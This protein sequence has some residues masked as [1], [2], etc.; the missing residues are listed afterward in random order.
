MFFRCGSRTGHFMKI[1]HR[2]ILTAHAAQP[3]IAFAHFA[4]LHTAVYLSTFHFTKQF[5]TKQF[6][7][8]QCGLFFQSTCSPI[9]VVTF[10]MSFNGCKL[11]HL[12]LILIGWCAWSPKVE[13]SASC[14]SRDTPSNDPR[15]QLCYLLLKNRKTFDISWAPKNVPPGTFQNHIPYEV[16]TLYKLGESADALTAGDNGQVNMHRVQPVIPSTGAVNE[17]NWEALV[18][19]DCFNPSIHYSDYVQFYRFK[20]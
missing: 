5:F 17:S 18:G 9:A 11:C 7:T 2:V 16:V 13:A 4:C 12:L 1:E 3:W 15:L 19:A 20:Q 8:I 6:F 10:A 14:A